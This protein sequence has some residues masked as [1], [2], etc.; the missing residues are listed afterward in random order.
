LNA[1]RTRLALG[2]PSVAARFLDDGHSAHLESYKG[3]RG[4]VN[5]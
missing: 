5:V 2:I 1:D 4:K 3:S